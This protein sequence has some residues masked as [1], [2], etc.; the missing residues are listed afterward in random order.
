V[1]RL[2]AHP[3]ASPAEEL[4]MNE[5]FVLQNLFREVFDDS[6]LV[7]EPQT[8][9][10]DVDGWDSVAQ[11]KLVLAIE[12]EFDLQLTE[13]EVSSIRTVGGF[14]DAIRERQHQSG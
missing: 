5:L 12:E 10:G 9:H 8:G 13:D 3:A 6:L 4:T 14:L 11:V 1:H 2:P 7:V